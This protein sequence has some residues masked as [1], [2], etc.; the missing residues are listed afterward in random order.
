MAAPSNARAGRK[1]SQILALRAECVAMDHR[2]LRKP[3]QH[4]PEWK[5]VGSCGTSSTAAIDVRCRE[6]PVAIS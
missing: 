4:A 1:A 3:E 5:Q 2:R 6:R